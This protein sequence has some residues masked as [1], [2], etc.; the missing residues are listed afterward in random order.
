MR[1]PSIVRRHWTESIAR[2]VASSL[3][4]SKELYCA[5]AMP[6]LTVGERTKLHANVMS[7]YRRATSE[8]FFDDQAAEWCLSDGDIY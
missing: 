4:L 2:S 1:K 3:L 8:G 7:V 5:G 6:I